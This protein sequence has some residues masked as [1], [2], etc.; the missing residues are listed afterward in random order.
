MTSDMDRNKNKSKKKRR[1][2]KNRVNSMERLLTFDERISDSEE[3]AMRGSWWL[4]EKKIAEMT[5]IELR[6]HVE[7]A[8]FLEPD[9]KATALKG[10]IVEYRHPKRLHSDVVLKQF[11]LPLYFIKAESDDSI[12]VD[13]LYPGADLCREIG[14]LIGPLYSYAPDRI[15]IWSVIGDRQYLDFLIDLDEKSGATKDV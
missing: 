3:D 7:K 12:C 13:L 4:S 15:Q 14:G 5:P 1:L 8:G 9:P 10:M 2:P 6:K 11:G